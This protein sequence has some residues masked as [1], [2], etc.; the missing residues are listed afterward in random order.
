LCDIDQIFGLDSR[1]GA[2]K[3]RGLVARSGIGIKADGIRIVGR[4]GVKITTGKMRGAKFGLHGETNS[5]G[6]KISMPAPK[7]ELVAGNNYDIVQGVALGNRTRDSLR[8]LHALIGEL[9]SAVFNLTLAQAGVDISTAATMA[10]MGVFM[11]PAAG[12]AAILGRSTMQKFSRVLNPLYQ[13]RTNAEMWKFNYLQ[14]S[15]PDYIVSRNV[16]TN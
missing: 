8:E 16:K 13:M 14:A 12:T 9:W 2:R 1:P 3:G 7:I 6:G 11:P 5:L 4:E 15:G 10:S